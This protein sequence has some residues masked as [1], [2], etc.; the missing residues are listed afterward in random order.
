MRAATRSK[1]GAAGQ[2]E[3]G[4]AIVRHSRSLPIERDWRRRRY[5]YLAGAGRWDQIVAEGLEY[6]GRT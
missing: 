1:S 5:N 6:V 2:R 3:P 4:S